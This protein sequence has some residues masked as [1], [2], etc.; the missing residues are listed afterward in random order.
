MDFMQA[1]ENK[2]RKELMLYSAGSQM[3]CPITEKCL[4][5]KTVM[6]VTTYVDG[7]A[8]VAKSFHHE[9]LN[10]LYANFVK[11]KDHPDL[12]DN[13]YIEIETIDTLPYKIFQT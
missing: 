13:L 2:I 3:F 10:A 12:P 9:A 4:D 8:M 7:K 6:V 1:F 5:W 11:M